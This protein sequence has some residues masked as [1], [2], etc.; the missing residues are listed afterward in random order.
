[1][2]FQHKILNN[3][4][5]SKTL[6]I[7]CQLMGYKQMEI[8]IYH[9]TLRLNRR[10][11][12]VCIEENSFQ[13]KRNFILKFIVFLLKFFQFLAFFLSDFLVFFQTIKKIEAEG[14]LSDVLNLLRKT[15]AGVLI[16]V[17]L[18]KKSVVEIDIKSTDF[19]GLTF[20]FCYWSTYVIANI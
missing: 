6:I 18:I 9:C 5:K 4:K 15:E 7:K 11:R 2:V 1:M 20:F 13:N 19:K 10:L 14:V 3:H 17:Q 12:K 16:N 8:E